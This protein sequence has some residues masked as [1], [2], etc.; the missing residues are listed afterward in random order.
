MTYANL[1]ALVLSLTLIHAG[2]LAWAEST[3]NLGDR[4]A[5]EDEIIDALTP[6]EPEQPKMRGLTRG[7]KLN[8]AASPNQV[9]AQPQQAAPE[10]RSISMDVKFDYNSAELSKYAMEQLHPLGMA[11]NSNELSGFR[12][13]V[14]GHTD[15]QGS[16]DYN[17]VLS[18][19][20][21]DRVKT[22]LVQNY[23]VDPGRIESVGRGEDVPLISGDP[24]N[25]ANRRVEIVNILN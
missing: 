12:F 13:R 2:S 15:G 20:R 24:N 4:V 17:L 21:A 6:T 19:R 23:G 25:G 18:K 16:S 1:P 10:P 3:T 22:H 11:L 7:I 14:E 9:P 5:D 8:N